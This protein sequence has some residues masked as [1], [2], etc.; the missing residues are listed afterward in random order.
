MITRTIGICLSSDSYQKICVYCQKVP[1]VLY[2]YH[3]QILSKTLLSTFKVTFND[4][5]QVLSN[6][7]DTFYF[8]HNSDIYYVSHSNIVRL[9]IKNICKFICENSN[10]RRGT[11]APPI[12][13]NCLNWQSHF[14]IYLY[15]NFLFT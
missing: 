10:Q 3:R 13:S 14:G 11:N 8:V 5:N 7:K 15:F 1:F 4:H 6:F 9:T 2:H 12:M